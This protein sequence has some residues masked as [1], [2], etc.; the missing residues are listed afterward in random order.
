MIHLRGL[1]YVALIL[2]LAV[3]TWLVMDF[4]NRVG[5]LN[6]ITEEQ[7]AVKVNYQEVKSTLGALEV[8]ITEAASDAAVERWAYEQ[9][10]MVRPGDHAIV[11]LAVG[12]V[13]PT[14]VPVPTIIQ[15]AMSHRDGWVALFLGPQTP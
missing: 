10:H 14:P 2:G 1:R 4:N 3:L 12:L 9:G 8:Q 6:R 15:P 5:E 13:T 7:K 11:P